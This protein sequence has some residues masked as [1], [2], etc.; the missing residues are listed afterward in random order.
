[1]WKKLPA[2]TSQ[3]AEDVLLWSKKN[4]LIKLGH[5][6][7]IFGSSLSSPAWH[8]KCLLNIVNV[9]VSELRVMDSYKRAI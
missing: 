8:Y 1:M 5:V 2:V 7:F 4:T 6:K 9:L 3:E